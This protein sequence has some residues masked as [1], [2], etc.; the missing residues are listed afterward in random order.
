MLFIVC[1]SLYTSRIVLSTLGIDDFGI[2]NIVGGVVALMSFLKTSMASATGRFL[3][4]SLGQ[5]DVNNLKRVFSVSIQIHIFIACIIFVIGEVVGLWFVNK[6]LNIPEVRLFAANW[7]FQFSLL[8]AIISL[9]Q[10]PY[11]ASLQAHEHLN[12]YAIIEIVHAC[13]KL[14]IVFLIEKTSFDKLIFYSV[15]MLCVSVIIISV[16]IFYCHRNFYE[17]CFAMHRDKSLSQKIL[18]F[19]ILDLFNNGSI[20]IR[21]QGI[22]ILLNKF[23]GIALNA[24]NGIAT[25]AGAAVSIFISNLTVALRPQLIKRYASGDMAGLQRLLSMS[26]IICLILIECAFIP[27]YL[28]MDTILTLWLGV[29]PQYAPSFAKF[30]LV[31]NALMGINS[32]F[33]AIIYAKGSIKN[34]NIISG[35]LHLLVV[36]FAYIALLF[37]DN[38][39]IPYLIWSVIAFLVLQINVYY[40]KRNVPLISYRVVFS[41]IKLPLLAIVSTALLSCYVNLKFDPSIFRFIFM[42]IFNASAMVVLIYIFWILPCFKGN[43]KKIF[44]EFL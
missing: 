43:I 21:Q 33:S 32:I 34:I 30:L 16:N 37:L 5:D 13:L 29:V 7:V 2:Y 15:L 27:I 11:T 31:A 44:Y 19:S 28:N 1:I 40:L 26:L 4:Y 38:P 9:L 23:F 8:T 42:L 18:S 36:I 39:N 24:A 22:N 41:L 17:C 20:V 35:I 25:Q 10:V 14:A 12:I 6:Q 3:T